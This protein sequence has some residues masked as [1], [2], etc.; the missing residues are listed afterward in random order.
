ML[1]YVYR[2]SGEISSKYRLACQETDARENFIKECC[3]IEAELESMQKSLPDIVKLDSEKQIENA[4][5]LAQVSLK[6]CDFQK[7]K[8]SSFNV[9]QSTKRR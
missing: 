5:S 9:I 3:E 6:S 8:Y 1:Q 2:A 7:L 4:V